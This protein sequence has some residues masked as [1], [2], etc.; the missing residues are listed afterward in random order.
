MTK[1]NQQ[2][3]QQRYI[4][5]QMLGQQMQSVQKQLHLLE[6]QMLEMNVAKEAVDD[7]S[8]TKPG[9]ELLIPITSGIFIKGQLKD[10]KNLIVNVGANTAVTKSA[11]EANKLLDEQKDEIRRIQMHLNAELQNLGQKAVLLEKGL[12]ELSS[13]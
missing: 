7:I 13:D 8:K 2:L 11:E 12:T 6:Q 4:E 3:L 1:E 5:L 9:T 10:S